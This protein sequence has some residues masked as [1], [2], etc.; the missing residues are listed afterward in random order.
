[1]SD[2][3]GNIG[4]ESVRLR[5]MALE[6]TQYMIFQELELMTGLLK[7]EKKGGDG[8]SKKEKEREERRAKAGKSVDVA[9]EGAKTKM[10]GFGKTLEE[11]GKKL[12]LLGSNTL[13]LTRSFDS[14]IKNTDYA[15]R[16]IAAGSKGMAGTIARFS[17]DSV[18]QLEE[19]YDVYKKLNSVGGTTAAGFEDL[20]ITAAQ[21]GV[22]MQEYAGLVTS[23]LGSLRMGGVSV[24]KSLE[25]LN[26]GVMSLRESTDGTN[27]Q[28]GR[29]G[30]SSY[31]YAQHILDSTAALGGFGKQVDTG[32]SSFQQQMLRTT[33][34]TQGLAEAFGG[35]RDEMLKKTAD[36]LKKPINRAILSAYDI[37][38][39]VAKAKLEAYAAI[40][41]DEQTAIKALVA[42]AGG[43]IN[44][45]IG[46]I[47]SI[48][49][50]M[51]PMVNSLAEEMAKT[52]DDYA[53]AIERVKNKFGPAAIDEIR[54]TVKTLAKQGLSEMDP[55][56]Q[57]VAGLMQNFVD[58]TG[59]F[60]Q[61]TSN[62]K[63]ANAALKGDAKDLDALGNLQR[64]NVDLAI[65]FAKTNK[66]L[67]TF[68]LTAAFATQTI[69]R[70][71]AGLANTGSSGI[72]KLVDS[73]GNEKGTV[74]T[75]IRNFLKGMKVDIGDIEKMLTGETVSGTRP[76]ADIQTQGTIVGDRPINVQGTK[77]LASQVDTAKKEA[78]ASAP[79][80]IYQK[81]SAVHLDKI[82]PNAR[83]TAFHDDRAKKGM[84]PH[85]EFSIDVVPQNANSKEQYE[86]LKKTFDAEMKA[87]GMNKDDYLMINEY[88]VEGGSHL[89]LQFANQ[90]AAKKYFDAYAKKYGTQPASAEPNAPT[91]PAPQRT[92]QLPAEQN[93]ASV[94]VK[95][96]STGVGTDTGVNNTLG[97]A[98]QEYQMFAA[99]VEEFSNKVIADNEQTRTVIRESGLS[100]GQLVAD[101][102]NKLVNGA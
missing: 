9:F 14:N 4:N 50:N 42:Q 26:K 33:K 86:E 101:A 44:D 8:L 61:L 99:L 85:G 41:L 102:T 58:N 1:M 45:S 98:S 88:G 55:A 18:A 92:S 7:A 37:P 80:N 30:V 12:E 16:N 11:A 28:F 24:R 32:S 71:L 90:K 73:L 47:S 93:T 31:N 54:E 22:S 52:P 100:T 72:D 21:M 59:N 2:V 84:R 3:T 75:E 53:G 6:D 48:S 13:R 25:S 35:S 82:I 39:E 34:V 29:L 91:V 60:K 23:N 64:S 97:Q 57:G 83:F 89:H 46:L 95:P 5:G 49:G 81:Q 79:T 27:E 74:H 67:N 10:G 94:A 77:V 56:L 20:R 68:G 19:Q 69:V 70:S 36:A 15:M 43:P 65:S 78:T 76:P 66:V 96:T 87:L 17:A 38:P 63:D 51:L 62:M 40:G